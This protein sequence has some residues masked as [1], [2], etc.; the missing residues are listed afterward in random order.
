MARQFKN[1]TAVWL[2]SVAIVI[3]IIGTV[4][5]QMLTRIVETAAARVQSERVLVGLDEVLGLMVDLE[6]GQRGYLLTQQEEFL[7]PYNR[8]MVSLAERF[9]SFH[10]NLTDING[11]VADLPR[12]EALWKDK[13]AISERTI[14]LSKGGHHAEAIRIVQSGVGRA[15]MDE[16]RLIFGRLRASER[17]RLAERAAL[18]DTTVRRTVAIVGF[19]LIVAF[20]LVGGAAIVVSRELRERKRAEATLR[21]EE[22]RL[23]EVIAT[24]QDVA[25]S[26]LDLDAVMRIVVT[27]TESLTGASG[28]VI[29]VPDGDD[30]LNRSASGT[31]ADKVGFRVKRAGSLSGLCTASGEILHCEDSETDPRVDRVACRKVGARSMIAVPLRQGDQTIAVLKT[32]AALPH[33]FGPREIETLQLIGGLL[34]SAMANATAFAAKEK[35]EEIALQSARHKSEFLANMSHEIRTPINGVIGMAGLLRDLSLTGEQRD[36]VDT[37]YRSAESLLSI[38]NDVLDFSKVEAGKIDLETVNF[39]LAPLLGDLKGAF[40]VA[41]ANK[42]LTLALES[43]VASSTY[44]KGDPGRLRQILTNLI[45]NAIKFTSVGTVKVCVTEESH[46]EHGSRIEFAVTDSGIGLTPEQIARLFTPFSQADSSTTRKYGGTGLGLSICKR[47][48]ELMGGEIGVESRIGAGSRFWFKVPLAR[49]EWRSV[50][51]ESQTERTERRVMTGARV[52]VAEDNPVNQKVAVLTLEKMG[53][54]VT[55]V[56]TGLAA[57]A[58]LKNGTFD[59]VLMDCQM[60]EMDGYEATKRIR[61]DATLANRNVP[62]I[63]MTA[64]AINGDREKCLAAGMSDYVSKPVKSRDLAAVLAKWLAVA[65]APVVEDADV[66]VELVETSRRPA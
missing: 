60:P 34:A 6:T 62:I 26:T 58:A 52:L 5:L 53:Y 36:Y 27:R 17:D 29:E 20:L 40:S 46:S 64:N 25:L 12:F 9:R 61:G 30:M 31:L 43:E 57:I 45:G 35:A 19:G 15:Y 32:I 38:I 16:L 4:C 44:F 1:R 37:I 65:K 59:V 54:A 24:Q 11:D 66:A 63:A 51:A 18:A 41:A 56:E 7:E 21:R 8:A 50:H 23:S 42:G 47:L 28:A 13:A 55:V 22:K 33:A 49:G 2:A 3:A 48:V 39:D 10:K 14:S